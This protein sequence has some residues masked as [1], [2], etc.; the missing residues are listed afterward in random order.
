MALQNTLDR[1]KFESPSQPLSNAQQ[2]SQIAARRWT[3]R[4]E[5]LRVRR[6]LLVVLLRNAHTERGER[7][8][9]EVRRRGLGQQ[10]LAPG[11]PNETRSISRRP[12]YESDS[13]TIHGV[14]ET[15]RDR[16]SPSSSRSSKGTKVSL[17]TTPNSTRPAPNTQYRFAFPCRLVTTVRF[18]HPIR[19][20][21]TVPTMKQR[22]VAL[23]KHSPSSSP[24]TVSTT[25]TNGIRDRYRGWTL[26]EAGAIQARHLAARAPAPECF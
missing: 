11:A 13:N 9:C 25:N 15:P 21:L 23:Q 24:D 17:E 14:L 3:S 16:T 6:G 1:P 5:D 18:K 20:L 8:D 22:S 26:R 7:G 2:D 12:R 10:H 4:A 19:T